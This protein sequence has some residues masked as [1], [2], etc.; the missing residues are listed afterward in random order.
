M[1]PKPRRKRRKRGVRGCCGMCMLQ[2]HACLHH[3]IPKPQEKRARA[4]AREQ[5]HGT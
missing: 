2:T 1:N 3:R 4:D 5:R